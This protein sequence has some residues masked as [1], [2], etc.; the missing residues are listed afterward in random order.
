MRCTPGRWAASTQTPSE[1]AAA[2][3]TW[4][5]PRQPWPRPGSSRQTR[6]QRL[7]LALGPPGRQ[8]NDRDGAMA[9]VKLLLGEAMRWTPTAHFVLDG[10]V[11]LEAGRGRRRAVAAMR[12]ALFAD[13]RFAL[14]A[15]TLGRAYDTYSVTGWRS[16]PFLPACPANPGP[17]R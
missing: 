1:T 12:Q 10:L 14:A 2:Q 8:R 11:A 7:A 3:A 16:A 15:F 13:S 17:S 5:R 9:Q 4:Q 6:G